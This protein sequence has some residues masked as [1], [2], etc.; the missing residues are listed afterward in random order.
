[1]HAREQADDKERT[2]ADAALRARRADETG[3]GRDGKIQ[4]RDKHE[5][6]RVGAPPAAAVADGVAGRGEDAFDALC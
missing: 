2:E 3:Q 5:R 4:A 6:D 1:M